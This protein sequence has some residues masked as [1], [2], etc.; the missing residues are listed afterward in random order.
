MNIKQQIIASCIVLAGS[1]FAFDATFS[2]PLKQG[3]RRMSETLF[4]T[5][6][7]CD[8]LSP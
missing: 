5:A 2:G 3:A 8:I 7:R 6:P 4:R 1:V